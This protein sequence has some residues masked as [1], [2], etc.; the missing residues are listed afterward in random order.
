MLQNNIP[1]LGSRVL[2]LGLAFKENCPDIRNTKVA[3][4]VA[5]LK[6]YNAL[7]DI[8]DPWVNVEQ[9]KHEYG[10]NC[11]AEMPTPGKYSAIVLAVGHREFVAL[12][13][14]GIRQLGQPNAVLFDVKSILPNGASNGRL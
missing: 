10:L 2:V 12:G 8:F 11:L 6:S 3:D 14:G 4:M 1:V 13:E 5:C 9:A 7:V